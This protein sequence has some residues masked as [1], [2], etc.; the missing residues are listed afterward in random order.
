MLKKNKIFNKILAVILSVLMISVSLPLTAMAADITDVGE[1]PAE[2]GVISGSLNKVGHELHYAKY[3][4]KTY[5]TFCTECGVKSPTGRVYDRSEFSSYKNKND[6]TFKEVAKYIYFGYTM[7]YGDGLPSNDEE[8]RAASATQQFVWETLKNAGLSSNCFTR[9]SWKSTYMS[10]SIFNDWKSKTD[11]YINLYYNTLPSFYNANINLNYNTSTT[12]T[13]SNGALQYYPTFDE[14]ADGINYK[15]T[16]GSNNLI[17]TATKAVKQ[18]TIGFNSASYGIF[19]GTPNG[20]EYN[21][22]MNFVSFEFNSG[23]VQNLMFSRYVD[24]TR[25]ILN[26][27]VEWG[28]IELTKEDIY[29]AGIDGTIFGLYTDKACT[30]RLATATSSNGKVKFEYLVPNTYYVKEIKASNGFLKSDKVIEVNVGNADTAKRT[31]K[32]EEPKGTITLTKNLDVS[33]TNGKYGDV[34]ISEAEYTL[35]AKEKITSKLNSHTFYEKNQEVAKGTIKVGKDGTVGTITWDKLPLG[36]YYIKETAN[37]KGTFIDKSTYSVKL[38]YKD[39]N[40]SVIV[41]NDSNSTDVVKSM[42]V[43]IFK[44]GTDGSSGLLKGIEGAEFTIKLNADYQKALRAGYSVEDIWNGKADSIAPTY[45]KVTSDNEGNAVTGYLPYGQYICKETKTPKDYEAANDFIFNIVNDE[46]EVKLEY[47]IKLLAVNNAPFEAPVKIIKKD[48]DSNKNVSMS[49]ATFKIKAKENIKNHT[50]G[51]VIFKAG[52]YV[53]YKVGTSKYNEFMTNSDGYVT[54]ATGNTY[55]S[56]ND[57]KGTVTTPF[58]LQAGTYE[59]IEIKEPTG[60]LMAEKTYPFT[61]TN[62]LDNDKDAD[63]DVVVNVIVTNEQP[64]GK[65]IINKD[66]VKRENMDKTFIDDIDYTKVGFSLTAAKD[67]IDMSDGSI[68]YPEGHEIGIYYLNADA[69]KII[70]DIWMGEYILKEVSTIDGGILDDTEY[71]IS[72]EMKDNKTNVYTH[73]VDID[74]YTTEVDYTKSDITGETELIGAELTVTD[75]DG[76]ELDKWI[77]TTKEHKIEGLVVGKT[78]KLIEDLAPLGYTI[79]NEIE[80]TV[81]NTKEIQQVKMLDKIVFIEKQ[82]VNGSRIAGTELT[83]FNS[84]TKNIVDKWIVGQHIIDMTDSLK[85][86]IKSNGTVSITVDTSDGNSIEYIVS[87]NNNTDEYS[88]IQK[89]DGEANYYIVDASGNEIAHMCRGLIEGESYSLHETSTVEG[90]VTAKPIEFDVTTEKTNQTVVMT[91]KQIFVSKTNITGD[92]ELEGAKLKVTDAEGNVVDEWTSTDTVHTVKGLVEGQTYTL[93]EETAPNGYVTATSIEFTVDDVKEN[94]TIQM[95]DKQVATSK[96]DITN[97]EELE[98][99]EIV[100]TDSE[101]NEVDKWTST[102]DIHY[103]NGLVEGQTYTMTEITAPYGY[104]IT[105]SITFVVSADKETQTVIMKDAPILSSVLVNKV[106]SITG[107]NIISKDFEFTLYSDKKCKNE[108]ITV[109]A[110]TDDG[111]ALFSELRY[112]TYFIKETKAPQG[113]MLSDEVVEIIIN[114]EGVFANGKELTEENG[115]YSIEYQNSLLPAIITGDS[116]RTLM[117]LTMAGIA[118]VFIIIMIIIKKKYKG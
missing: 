37:P 118:V 53:T 19:M 66:F 41:N 26:V 2:F 72:F 12:I 49:S 89:L 86:E 63:G 8:Y 109:N 39:E 59:I 77:S 40:T 45:A 35:Y 104:E 24:P 105:N 54:P 60:F 48:L 81:A 100:V 43:R 31:I 111:T 96:V 9:G 4:G 107:E 71:P 61:I 47:K 70:D 55:A 82:D 46:S 95:I 117:Y 13:D 113:Y 93:T 15:H 90:Y 62:I 10:D 67:I 42:K 23:S 7:L 17:I 6:A 14:T 108:I 83:V 38:T 101:G 69:T 115:I 27:N 87:A 51:E 78:Y 73:T 103:I 3:D 20:K 21:D 98:G 110:N 58:K 79:A 64:K 106:D 22:T 68:V 32:N 1:N 85:D 44:E 84:R 112:G 114:D 25:F 75:L 91:D 28:D 102:K 80:F 52:E 99:A 5:I 76:N 97:G 33:K 29:G 11:Q 30:N 56:T 57:E 65:I 34:V 92:K 74:N 36:S 116:N 16:K 88:V 18:H 50:T 94:K